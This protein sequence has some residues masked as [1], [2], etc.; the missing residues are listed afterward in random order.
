[1]VRESVNLIRIVQLKG[2]CLI[3]I[4]VVYENMKQYKNYEVYLWCTR[5]FPTRRTT[6]YV[7]EGKNLIT[8]INCRSKKSA[9]LRRTGGGRSRIFRK[10]LFCRIIPQLDMRT[11]VSETRSASGPR[12]P[13][14]YL[15]FKEYHS[16]VRG[17]R[18]RE[19][20]RLIF[21]ENCYLSY[22]ISST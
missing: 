1:M 5:K 19:L 22:V 17:F 13:P 18:F 6:Q 11:F 16:H 4:H 15:Y 8:L 3:L 7:L 10:R 21:Y 9:N 14:G 2:V 20:I 12:E